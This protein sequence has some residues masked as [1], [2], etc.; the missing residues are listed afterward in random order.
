L[1]NDITDS[2]DFAALKGTVF[3]R[4]AKNMHITS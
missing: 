1:A 2:A 3:S 4:H